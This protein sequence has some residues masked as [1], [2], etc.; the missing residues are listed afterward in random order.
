MKTKDRSY[1]RPLVLRRGEPKVSRKPKVMPRR[2]AYHYYSWTSPP[3]FLRMAWNERSMAVPPND[4]SIIAQSVRRV[5]WARGWG[6]AAPLPRMFKRGKIGPR[7]SAPRVKSHANL[8]LSL[9][10]LQAPVRKSAEIQRPAYRTLPQLP[11]QKRAQGAYVAADSVQ[12]IGLVYHRLEKIEQQHIVRQQIL[13]EE[14]A[15]RRVHHPGINTHNDRDEEQRLRLTAAGS[16]D[17]NITQS[18]RDLPNCELF[19]KPRPGYS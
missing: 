14:R 18:G 9:Q 16:L 5:K 6:E 19:G 4:G 11:P 8:R 1:E 7:L 3:P 15:A 12:R 17:E 2:C 10:S 13:E